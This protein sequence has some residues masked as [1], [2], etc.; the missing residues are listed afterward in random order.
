[1]IMTGHG[2]T[3]IDHIEFT[4]K[5]ACTAAMHQINSSYVSVHLVKCV[6]K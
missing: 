1:M 2:R 4:S 6:K 3:A 5:E